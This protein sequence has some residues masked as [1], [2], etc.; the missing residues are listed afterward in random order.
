MATFTL[1]LFTDQA[2]NRRG[3]LFRESGCMDASGPAPI[4]KVMRLYPTVGGELADEP[5]CRASGHKVI[6]F[7]SRRSALKRAAREGVSRVDF[8]SMCVLDTGRHA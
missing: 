7:R 2:G 6:A 8:L 5:H 3:R 4:G 1:H